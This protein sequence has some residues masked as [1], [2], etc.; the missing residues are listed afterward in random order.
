[1][2][3]RGRLHGPSGRR[4]RGVG[5]S[6]VGVC[7]V[8]GKVT[9]VRCS[10][11]L[12][13]WAGVARALAPAPTLVRRSSCGRR[14]SSCSRGAVRIGAARAHSSPGH[15]IGG[16]TRVPSA[17]A[18]RFVASAYAMSG[19]VARL[20]LSKNG[21]S[22]AFWTPSDARRPRRAGSCAGQSRR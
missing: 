6:K 17:S 9:A 13:G 19:S 15:T 21:M 20:S 1:M 11:R 22:P 5:G 2:H 3:V 12:L 4:G 8:N 7:G 16:T 10:L 18:K 14:C